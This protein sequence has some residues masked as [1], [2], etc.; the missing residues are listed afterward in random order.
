MLALVVVEGRLP[1]ALKGMQVADGCTPF[2]N[3]LK[4]MKKL[5]FFMF[6]TTFTLSGQSETINYS[7]N[8]LGFECDTQTKTASVVSCSG[9][10]GVIVIPAKVNASGTEYAV[11]AIGQDINGGGIVVFQNSGATKITISEGVKE[12]CINALTCATLEEVVLPK[13]IT[14][15]G[16]YA[17][18]G[19]TSLKKISLPDGVTTIGDNAFLGCSSLESAGISKS[20]TSI[21]MGIF[22][23]CTTLNSITVAEDNPVYDSRNNCN[24]IIVSSTNELI[25]GCMG[26]AIPNTV[27]RIGDSAFAGLAFTQFDIPDNITSLGMSVFEACTN[28]TQVNIPEGIKELNRGI[29]L[30]CTSLTVINIPTSVNTIGDF[31]FAYTPIATLNIPSGVTTLGNGIVAFCENLQ[32]VYVAYANPTA[33]SDQVFIAYDPKT[34]QQTGNINA[35]LYVPKGTKSVYEKTDG[36][37]N[38]TNII[39]VNENMGISNISG[40]ETGQQRI[41]SLDGRRMAASNRLFH[42]VLIANGRKVVR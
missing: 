12:I 30:A 3:Y 28:L 2:L 8:G 17:F 27:T 1:V 4:N 18:N 9:T 29:F 31:A 21:G 10:T 11:T 6:A 7:E 23:H 40:T 39:E 5:F 22:A 26:T 20:V 37:K 14:S 25:Q 24:A 33:I 42:G 34:W 35:T 16:K 15:I 19:C 41:Y 32:S 36:W 38:F 13:S